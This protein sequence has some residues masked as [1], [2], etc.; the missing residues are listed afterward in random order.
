M[1]GVLEIQCRFQLGFN[2]PENSTG[3]SNRAGIFRSVSIGSLEDGDAP[4]SILRTFLLRSRLMQS[5]RDT[6][7]GPSATSPSFNGHS[8]R[9][10]P[11]DPHQLSA[12]TT[13]KQLHVNSRSHMPRKLAGINF[14]LYDA[15]GKPRTF[16]NNFT[17]PTRVVLIISVLNLNGNLN[18]NY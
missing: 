13:R 1:N 12:H 8:V 15:L 14:T 11:T 2:S 10:W 4:E 17:R 18:G 5:V 9:L 6:S 7:I 16:L 3:K